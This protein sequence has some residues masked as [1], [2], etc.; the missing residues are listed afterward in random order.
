[1]C[2][3]IEV[4]NHNYIACK[5]CII[6]LAPGCCEHP[7]SSILHLARGPLAVKLFQT[8]LHGFVPFNT[9]HYV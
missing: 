9:N 3:V 2:T 1:M 5:A 6:R 8:P 4:L 7:S